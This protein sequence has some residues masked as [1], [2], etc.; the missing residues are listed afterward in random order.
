VLGTS[1][2]FGWPIN[3]TGLFGLQC[4]GTFTDFFKPVP[5]ESDLIIYVIG[6]AGLFFKVIDARYCK[7]STMM[8]TNIDFEMLGD[9]LGNPVATTAIV[10]RMI[11]HAII[12]NIEGPSWRM[13]ESEQLNQKSLPDK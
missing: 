2:N 4:D 3:L 5:L 8:T 11:H 1:T 6:W 10:D 12:I 7:S 13:H 9:Y